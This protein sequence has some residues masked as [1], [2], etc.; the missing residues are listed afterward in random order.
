M[1]NTLELKAAIMRKG[2]TAES[3]A[4]AIGISRQSM[5][6]KVNNKREFISSEIAKISNTLQLTASERDMIF[7]GIKVDK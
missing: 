7:F 5:S 3:L 6:Y 4:D 2:F 1:T